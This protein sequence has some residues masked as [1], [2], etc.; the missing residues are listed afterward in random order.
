MK[1]LQELPPPQRLFSDLSASPAT[2]E[3]ARAD[4]MQKTAVLMPER[5]I[6]DSA[7]VAGGSARAAGSGTGCT[8]GSLGTPLSVQNSVFLN[9]HHHCVP[10]TPAHEGRGGGGHGGVGGATVVVRLF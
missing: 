8:Q 5:Q 9:A 6:P 7:R 1:V 4:I 10:S 2:R 3:E